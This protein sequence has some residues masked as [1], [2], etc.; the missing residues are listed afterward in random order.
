MCVRACVCACVHVCACQQV[1]DRTAKSCL[2]FSIITETQ[3]ADAAAVFTT[4]QA[5]CTDAA[6]RFIQRASHWG[7]TVSIP[8]S[9][10]MS[11][12]SPSNESV[13]GSGEAEVEAVS[14]FPYL[15]S[16]LQQDGLASHGVTNRIVKASCA[17]ARFG[18]LQVSIFENTTI[19]LR[20]RR[21]VYSAVI[22]STLLY[23]S[24]EWTTKA[25]DL[26]HLNVFHRHGVRVIVDVDKRRQWDDHTTSEVLAKSH[27]I[28]DDIAC[29]VR[30]RRLCWLGHVVRMK[31]SRLQKHT[32]FG[33]LLGIRPRHGPKKR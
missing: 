22:L 32:L 2:K 31:E 18:S 4:S 7:L 15:G 27:G 28:P 13:G 1:G 26:R 11:V 21:Q 25:H 33:E 17:Y 8:K 19:S 20:C 24:E 9:K 6:Q 3:F 12:T 23:G 14:S 5:S 10:V 30:E 29:M 16:V